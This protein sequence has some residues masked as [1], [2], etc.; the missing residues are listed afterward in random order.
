MEVIKSKVKPKLGRCRMM[1]DEPIDEKLTAEHAGIAV[2]C[3]FSKPHFTL[4]VGGM[5]SGKTSLLISMLKGVLKKTAH[6][7]YVI[8]PEISLHSISPQDNVFVKHL[9][10]GSLYHE[11][12]PEILEEVYDRAKASAEQDEYTY[13]IV[14]DFGHIMKQQPIIKA[15]ERLIIKMRHLKMCIFILTQNYYQTPLKLREICTNVVL[16]NTN[17]SQNFKF[18][19]EAFQYT[20]DQFLRLMTHCPTIHDWALVNMKYKRI[21]NKEWDEIVF[22][23]E[24]KG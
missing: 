22:K 1:C 20:E 13:L 3:C 8:I 19:N 18:Y 4:F 5:G 6:N 16:W 11:L 14:D 23:D 2:D 15:L 12:S 10:E 17:K 24:K 7:M 21:F 9:P